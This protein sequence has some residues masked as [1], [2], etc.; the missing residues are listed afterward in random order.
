MFQTMRLD[1]LLLA[2]AVSAPPDGK[3]YVHGGGV[4]R[5]TVPHLPFDVPQLAVLVRLEIDE[6]EIGQAHEFGF[7]L[8]DPS[9]ALVGP[10]P[11]PRFPAELPPPPSGAD[12]PIEGEPR[13][14]VL[15]LNIGGIRVAH[16]GLYTFSF[17]VDRETIGSLRFVVVYKPAA[18]NRADVQPNR[19]QRRQQP[20]RRN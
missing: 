14:V 19:A 15:V 1:A 9:G 7:D 8:R 18:A 3:F 6:H 12:A 2:D 20:R 5:I 4:T 16:P 13:F 10:A 11:A 17:Q